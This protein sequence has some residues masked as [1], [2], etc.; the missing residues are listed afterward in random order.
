[1]LT[2]VH[3]WP[4]VTFATM[5]TVRQ[6]SLFTLTALSPDMEGAS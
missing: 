6:Q 3:A 4:Q 5:I 2:Y 1:M